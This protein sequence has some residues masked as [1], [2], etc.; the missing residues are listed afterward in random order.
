MTRRMGTSSPKS[1]RRISWTCGAAVP[2]AALA[3]C[4]AELGALVTGVLADEVCDCTTCEA[5][6]NPAA[7]PRPPADV[8]VCSSGRG[9]WLPS[10]GMFASELPPFCPPLLLLLELPCA[11]RAG[12]NLTCLLGE[13]ARPGCLTAESHPERVGRL[14][15][16]LIGPF[17]NSKRR[18]ETHRWCLGLYWYWHGCFRCWPVCHPPRRLKRT[19]TKKGGATM[20]L[21]Q[22]RS[23]A[24]ACPAAL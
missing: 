3:G 4:R 7:P 22:G 23:L 11:V 9:S 1:C 14:Q 24:A 20:G 15:P 6:A 18:E 21:K 2:G 5:E 13:L 10:S 8:P 17:G 12:G 19:R 16:G